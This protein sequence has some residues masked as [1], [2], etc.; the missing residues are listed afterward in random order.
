MTVSYTAATINW[1]KA[2]VAIREALSTS[3]LC[4]LSRSCPQRELLDLNLECLVKFS[5]V[6]RKK[7][8]G[9]V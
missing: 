5:G 8:S 6:Q 7:G 3:L 2:I 9:T 1:S 4:K